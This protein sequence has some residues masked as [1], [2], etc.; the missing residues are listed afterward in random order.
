VALPVR[1]R[2]DPVLQ[3][4]GRP[5]RALSPSARRMPLGRAI[6][7]VHREARNSTRRAQSMVFECHNHSELAMTVPVWAFHG[8]IARKH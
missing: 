4:R 3:C 6:Y 7:S 1:R 8:E 2:A 5:V